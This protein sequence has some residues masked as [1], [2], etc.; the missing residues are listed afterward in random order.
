MALWKRI[1]DFPNYEVSDTGK[2]RNSK[3]NRILKQRLNT[4]GYDRVCL[5]NSDGVSDRLVHRLVAEYFCD[6]AASE[7]DVNHKDGCKT[8]NN[9]ENLEWCTRSH[10]VKHAYDNRLK[11]PSGPHSIRKVRIVET[12]EIY[13]SQRECARAIDGSQAHIHRCLIGQYSQYKGYHF[14]YLQPDQGDDA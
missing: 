3:T 4:Y 1:D 11:T 14:E 7:L 10:N 12:D 5:Y 2:V 9:A 6:G 8:N 13:D